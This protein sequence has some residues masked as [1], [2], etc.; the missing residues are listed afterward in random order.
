[1]TTHQTWLSSS[2]IPHPH[3]DALA[4]LGGVIFAG[5]SFDTL[6]QGG[7]SYSRSDIVSFDANTGAVSDLFNPIF[8]GG[9]IWALAT[10]S[11]NQFRLCRR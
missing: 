6:T 1:M 11:I 5:G 8:G 7:T 3:V 10:D 2:A 4:D 9:Q